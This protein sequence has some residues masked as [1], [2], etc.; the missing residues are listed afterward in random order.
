MYNEDIRWLVVLKRVFLGHSDEEVTL[1][2]HVSRSFQARVLAQYHSTGDVLTTAQ[3]GGRR[4]RRFNREMEWTLINSVIDTPCLTLDERRLQLQLQHGVSVS[5]ATLCRAMHNC[6]LSYQ[7]LQH[8]ALR[9][10]EIKAQQFWLQIAT[11]FSLSEILVG[12]ETSKESS[13]LRRARGWGSMGVTP[14][15]RDAVLARGGSVSALTYFSVYG[16]EAWR[17]TR[18][19]FNAVTFQAATDEMLLTPNAVTGMTLAS[20]YRVLLMDNA[21]IHKDEEYLLHLQCFIR[22]WFI[23]PYCYHLSPLDNGAYGCVWKS[24]IAHKSSRT[25]QHTPS[26]HRRP[27]LSWFVISICLTSSLLC[28]SVRRDCAA[29]ASKRSLLFPDANR[30]STRRGL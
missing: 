5:V 8:Y 6:R 14:Y 16:F 30:R 23:P 20:R 24:D 15:E 25:Q 9:R 2:L 21:P 26:T 1:A 28:V 29:H 17:F 27:K 19:R 22:V 10:D 11:F 4:Q 13:I 3:R 18:G 12:D 7:S